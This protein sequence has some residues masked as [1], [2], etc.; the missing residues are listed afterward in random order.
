ML[1]LWVVHV[2]RQ[3]LARDAGIV[4][5]LPFPSAFEHENALARL[6]EAAGSDLAAEAASDDE[7]VEVW[8]SLFSLSDGESEQPDL[9][10]RVVQ[11]NSLGTS[12]RFRPFQ[13]LF[14]VKLEPRFA[15]LRIDADQVVGAVCVQREPREPIP[16]RSLA[17]VRRARAQHL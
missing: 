14:A 7:C 15:R 3:V 10:D 17:A 2:E 12:Q 9:G 6:G 11:R 8:H 13:L 5:G 4:L 16:F 1:G